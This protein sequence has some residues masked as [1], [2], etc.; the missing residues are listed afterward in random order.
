MGNKGTKSIIEG[1]FDPE[2]NH[3]CIDDETLEL[4]NDACQHRD[5]DRFCE[6]YEDNKFNHP[7]PLIKAL[8]VYHKWPECFNHLI[9]TLDLEMYKKSL[10]TTPTRNMIPQ[11]YSYAD[12]PNNQKFDIFKKQIIA[13]RPR[14]SKYYSDGQ[15]GKK[16]CDDLY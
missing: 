15:K 16:C 5:I 13:R 1:T 7:L 9:K 2:K 10:F 11:F 12:A 14:L 4:I 6:L 8:D 3:K